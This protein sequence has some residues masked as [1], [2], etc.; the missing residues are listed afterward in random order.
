MEKSNF[1]LNS[2]ARPRESRR[3]WLVTGSRPI[4]AIGAIS[5]KKRLLL[6]LLV[7]AALVRLVGLT[8]VREVIFDEVHFGKF[9]TAYCCSHDRIF[10]IH[11]PHAKLLIAGAARLFGYRGGFSFKQIGMAYP[12]DFPLFGFR[13]VPALAGIGIV[14]LFYLFLLQ[15]GASSYAGFAGALCLAFDNLFANR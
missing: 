12:T 3:L 11:P 1:K 14:V 13:F 15:L 6:V 10:D 4:T 9:A 8:H 2:T 7:A 5:L